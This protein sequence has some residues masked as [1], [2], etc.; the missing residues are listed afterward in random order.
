M[1]FSK[2]SRIS[3]KLLELGANTLATLPK[4]FK[5]KPSFD[6]HADINVQY[7]FEGLK[8]YDLHIIKEEA[9]LLC[10]YFDKS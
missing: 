6:N 1:N 9:V 5:S 7:F 8:I 3:Q 10:R 2:L 4:I